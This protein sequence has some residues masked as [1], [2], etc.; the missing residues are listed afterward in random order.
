MTVNVTDKGVPVIQSGDST[1]NDIRQEIEDVLLRQLPRIG[2]KL[3]SD[4]EPS[5][6]NILMYNSSNEQWEPVA[7]SSR[8]V[9]IFDYTF[10]SNKSTTSASY[11]TLDNGAASFSISRAGNYEFRCSCNFF[12]LTNVSSVQIEIVMTHSDGSTATIGNTNSWTTYITAG[13]T[14]HPTF[15][16]I[17]N[18]KSGTWSARVR[19]RRSFGP[20]TPH[21]LDSNRSTLLLTAHNVDYY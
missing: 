16:E 8:S 15:F 12:S 5:S 7:R 18:L 14:T 9:D 10:P 3:V 2:T 4:D 21:V 19:W 1:V 6:G 17:A 13:S 11:V 20:G